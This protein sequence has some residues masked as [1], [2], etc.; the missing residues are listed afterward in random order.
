MIEN[1]SP[2]LHG[3]K[4]GTMK[5]IIT[6]NTSEKI[7][8]TADEIRFC[9][10]KQLKGSLVPHNMPYKLI[11]LNRQEAQALASILNDWLKNK[12]DNSLDKG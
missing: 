4:G 1:Y 10:H 9:L 7:W 5:H 3:E 2:E 6:D 12:V 8:V 11:I